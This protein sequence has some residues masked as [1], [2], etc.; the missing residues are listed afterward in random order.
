MSDEILTE[1]KAIRDEQK[2]QAGVL[3]NI[4]DM[5]TEFHQEVFVGCVERRS[6]TDRVTALESSGD[7]GGGVRMVK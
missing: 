1:L 6:L 3:Q 7:N 4:A 2:R 5:T